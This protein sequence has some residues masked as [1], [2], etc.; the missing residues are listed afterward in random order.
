[1]CEL[2]R[3]CKNSLIKYGGI[4]YQKSFGEKL[5]ETPKRTLLTS[6]IVFS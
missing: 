6:A 3:A 4:I 5:F 1:M 2:Q